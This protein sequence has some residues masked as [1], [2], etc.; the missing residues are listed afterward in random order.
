MDITENI[1]VTKINHS[2]KFKYCILYLVFQLDKVK[3]KVYQRV[4]QE[5]TWDRSLESWN[6]CKTTWVLEKMS[7]R[8]KNKKKKDMPCMR[9]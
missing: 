8:K 6:G 4:K 9:T 7:R 2:N 1:M 5:E 3:K